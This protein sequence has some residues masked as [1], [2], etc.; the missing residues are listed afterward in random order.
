MKYYINSFLFTV[1]ALFSFFTT[2][3]AIPITIECTDSKDATAQKGV[4][5]VLS[6]GDALFV[7]EC[8]NSKFPVEIKK[9]NSKK[10]NSASV[11][12]NSCNIVDRQTTGKVPQT[13]P[14]SMLP[15]IIPKTPFPFPELPDKKDVSEEK[16]ERF[17]VTI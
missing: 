16:K 14:P 9:D 1:I 5:C 2:C 8:D 10:A 11:D 15:F 6:V 12:F 3:Q 17:E 13:P 7:L 4:T